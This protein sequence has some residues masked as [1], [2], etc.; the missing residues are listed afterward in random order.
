MNKIISFIKAI[1]LRQ[2]LVTFFMGTLLFLN[3]ACSGSAQAKTP[4]AMKATSPG[5]NPVGQN[6]PYEGG[7][8]NFTDAAPSAK[9]VEGTEGKVQRLIDNAEKIKAAKPENPKSLLESSGNPL[10][11]AKDTGDTLKARTKNAQQEAKAVGDRVAGSSDRAGDKAQELGD[12]I[13]QGAEN[14]KDNVFGAGDKVSSDAGRAA[15][16]IKDKAAAGMK[17]ANRAM[18][19]AAKQT[20]RTADDAGTAATRSMRDMVN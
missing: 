15:E 12:R 3:T 14:V 1:R 10:E 13:K 20:A 5:P 7:M 17:N 4:G 9:A 11:R 8:N 16:G 2:V 19:D 18:N 6:Q